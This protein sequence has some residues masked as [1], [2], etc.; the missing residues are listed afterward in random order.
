MTLH[1]HIPTRSE[2]EQLLDVRDP[3]CVSL[4][5]PTSPLTHEAQA[6]R[7][8]LKTLTADATRQLEEAGVAGRAVTELREPLEELVDDDDF[9]AEQARSLAIFAA[10]GAVRT[11]RLP[12]RL[13]SEVEVGDR[14]YVKPLLRAVT[15]PQAAF[16]LALAAGS[17]RLVEI[18]P[19]EPPFG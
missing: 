3:L 13:T 6:G 10:P 5:V 14:F 4:Y 16:V 7:I 9:W 18:T 15:F 8:E 11:F 19:D 2:L 12:N 17:V 1:T